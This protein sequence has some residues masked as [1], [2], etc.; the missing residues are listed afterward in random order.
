M[1]PYQA[2]PI[3]YPS[4]LGAALRVGTDSAGTLSR[5]FGNSPQTP[6]SGWLQSGPGY[7]SNPQNWGSY[8]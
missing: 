6:N 1:K 5:N 7:S 4:L 8:L 2:Q 3:T